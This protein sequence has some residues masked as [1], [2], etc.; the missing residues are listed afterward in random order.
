MRI[1]IDIDEVLAEF[2]ESF[3]EFYNSKYKSNFKKE[4]FKSYQFEEILGG[5][6]EEAVELIKEH[7]YGGEIKL[8]D[9]ALESIKE[10]AKKYELIILTAR[11]PMFKD[12]TENFLKSHFGDIF[13]QI[14]YTG[15]SFQKYGVTKSDL[16]KQLNIEII[17]E[18]NKI[19][20]KECAEKGI[21][22]LLFDKPWN[23]IDEYMENII[24]VKD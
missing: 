24:R 5:T 13:S 12:K 11:H 22:V 18:D 4:D 7:D 19:F 23:Q 1:G 16:C 9:G 14:L 15:E 20:S 8:V 2:L 3:L 17:I 6:H 10:L 21:R